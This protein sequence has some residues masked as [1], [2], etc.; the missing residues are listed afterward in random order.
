[1]TSGGRVMMSRLAGRD[2]VIG[3]SLSVAVSDGQEGGGRSH[4]GAVRAI[5]RW[6]PGWRAGERSDRRRTGLASYAPARARPGVRRRLQA[7]R[8]A[9]RGDSRQQRVAVSRARELGG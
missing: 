8:T 4:R 1:M 3:A 6:L 9:D 5:G 2:L 7:Y